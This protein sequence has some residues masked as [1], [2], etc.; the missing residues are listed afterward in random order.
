MGPAGGGDFGD[1]ALNFGFA[2][3]IG[4][5]GLGSATFFVD[6]SAEGFGGFCGCEVVDGYV[7][8]GGGEGAGH[9]G[10]EAA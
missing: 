8:A 2:G 4:P 1:E 6:F 10:A 5:E 7:V 3:D 9:G